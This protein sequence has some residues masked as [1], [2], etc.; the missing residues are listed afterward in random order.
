MALSNKLFVGRLVVM[1][2]TSSA[3]PS[4]EVVRQEPFGRVVPLL[5]ASLLLGVGA[6]LLLALVLL[7]AHVVSFPLNVWWIALNQAYD[8]LQLYGWAGLFVIG[9]VLHF[10]PRLRGVPLVAPWL[11][12]W[13]VWSQV[14]ALLLRVLSQPLLVITGKSFWR[15]LLVLS[16]AFE[17]AAFGTAAL[18]FALM[19]W[20]GTRSAVRVQYHQAGQEKKARSVDALRAFL[21][22]GRPKRSIELGLGGAFVSMALAAL[23][24]MGNVV[25]AAA[26]TGLVLGQGDGLNVV[27]GLFGF[28]V[29]VVLMLSAHSL[30][31]YVERRG[32]P[33]QVFWPLS[34]VYFV[35]LAFTFIGMSWTSSFPWLSV[36]SGFGMILLAMVLLTFMAVFLSAMR[37]RERLRQ[38]APQDMTQLGVDV[39]TNYGP[40]VL[41]IASSYLWAALGAL[42]LGV[43]GV[44][45]M[46]GRS[47]FLAPDAMYYSFVFGF[48]ALLLAGVSVRMFPDFSGLKI[49]G[50]AWVTALFWI[51]NGAALLHVAPLLFLPLLVAWGNMGLTAYAIMFD[52][53]DLFG[54]A[55]AI[56][57][58]IC[59]WPVLRASNLILDKDF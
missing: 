2:D 23:V 40:F 47:P 45:E 54:L 58:A 17:C 37:L 24:N 31:A 44:A 19:I 13:I 3:L 49:A 10:L 9:I 7:V 29:P 32:F 55:F 14:V 11:I 8:H 18:L 22:A 33:Q 6:G 51:G 1:R 16:G 41:L 15:I 5:K 36:M 28:L 57:L 39:R 42:L 25:Q 48:I 59:L 4:V 38:Q 46:L 43:N 35:G 34:A 50:P 52:F 20:R 26:G 27:L 30:P 21:Y 12:P 56:C 53:A